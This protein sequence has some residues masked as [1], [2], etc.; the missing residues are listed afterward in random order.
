MALKTHEKFESLKPG[1]TARFPIEEASVAFGDE[2]VP[3]TGHSL[4][5]NFDRFVRH[6]RKTH[7]IEINDHEC[8]VTR[9]KAP[10]GF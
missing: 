7:R 1:E 5:T 10:D 8:V 4:G 9:L 6:H 2:R 3:Q